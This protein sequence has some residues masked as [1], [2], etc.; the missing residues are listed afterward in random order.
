MWYLTELSDM[1]HPERDILYE[2]LYVR[3]PIY[4]ILLKVSY[5][6]LM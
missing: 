1:R 4:G 6:Y 2:A 3:Y 5:N